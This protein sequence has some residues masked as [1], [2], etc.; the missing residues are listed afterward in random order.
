MNLPV[1][2]ALQLQRGAA[3]GACSF[4]ILPLVADDE[5]EVQ[6]ELP[7]ESCFDEQ[8]G[9][10]APA[11]AM[12]V[13]VVRTKHDV[14]QR[15]RAPEQVVH[16]VQFSPGLIAAGKPRLVGGSNEN[17]ARTFEFLQRRLRSLHHLELLEG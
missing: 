6:V 4:G 13:L 15:E 2:W 7:F 16:A 8:P 5:G 10:R 14:I 11:R 12:I 3:G 9:S 1:P 17:E